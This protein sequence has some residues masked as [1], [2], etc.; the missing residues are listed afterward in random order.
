MLVYRVL[1]RSNNDPYLHGTL[2]DQQAIE[3]DEGLVGAAGLAKNNC[4]NATTDTVG[5]IGD[6]STLD[7]ANGFSEI[8]LYQTSWVPN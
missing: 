5:T 4:C 3:L 6:D 7:R 2:V 8:F 1:Y